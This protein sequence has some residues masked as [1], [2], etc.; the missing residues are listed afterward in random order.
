MALVESLVTFVVGVFVGGF[1]IHVGAALIAG[2][3]DYGRAVWTAVGGALVWTLVGSL[4]GGIPLLGPLLTFGAYLAVLRL[5]Y[6]GGW[7]TA[8][9][10]ALVAW[11]TLVAAYAV[12]GPFGLGVFDPVGVPF[13]GG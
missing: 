3:I 4:F 8:G 7:V 12:L 13:V 1:G 9:G 6:A 10:I 11:A 5:R 2:E